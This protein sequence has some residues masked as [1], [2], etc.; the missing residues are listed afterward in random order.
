[1][2]LRL[3]RDD[4]EAARRQRIQCAGVFV[5]FDEEYE[6][7]DWRIPGTRR[8]IAGMVGVSAILDGSPVTSTAMVELLGIS[9][10]VIGLE[11]R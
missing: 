11:M 8:S 7:S 5:S 10:T 1:M 2:S 6:R 3:Q 4:L 9:Q